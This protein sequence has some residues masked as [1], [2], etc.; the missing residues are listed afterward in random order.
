MCVEDG[1]AT[2]GLRGLGGFVLNVTGER[3]EPWGQ[4][5]CG[6]LGPHWGHMVQWPSIAFCSQAA[7]MAGDLTIMGSGK[8][9]V[10]ATQPRSHLRIAP[11]GGSLRSLHVCLTPS[12]QPA[13]G[14]ASRVAPTGQCRRRDGLLRPAPPGPAV[15]GV[16]GCSRAQSPSGAEV[17][18]APRL[19]SPSPR[20]GRTQHLAAS[21]ASAPC[22]SGFS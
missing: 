2:P 21:S 16:R 19:P 10:G 11:S 14:A 3:T 9:S 22:T 5:G 13:L 12:P 1:Q 20:P 15:E 7:P 17:Q 6:Q 18:G 4:S 8:T